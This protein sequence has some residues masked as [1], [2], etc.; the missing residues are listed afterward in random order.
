MVKIGLTNVAWSHAHVMILESLIKIGEVG[1]VVERL[2]DNRNKKLILY[3]LG[4]Q[5]LVVYAEASRGIN[6]FLLEESITRTMSG[7]CR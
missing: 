4:I 6:F 2:I 5:L 7:S 3:G 1:C